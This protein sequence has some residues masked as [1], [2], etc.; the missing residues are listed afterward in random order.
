MTDI[1]LAAIEARHDD[2][3]FCSVMTTDGERVAV[4]LR[5][6]DTRQVLDALHTAEEVERGLTDIIEHENADREALEAE[7]ARLRDLLRR[8]HDRLHSGQGTNPSFCGRVHPAL[9]STEEPR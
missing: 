7:N 2:L 9:A 6:C 5:D 8:D 1:D 4:W 3:H